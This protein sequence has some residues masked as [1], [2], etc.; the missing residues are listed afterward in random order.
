MSENFN[1]EIILPEKI[2]LKD[3]TTSVTIPSFEGD[4]TILKDH[5]SLI[6][7]L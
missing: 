6:A 1:L 3:Q 2:L 5:I 4:M 7:I